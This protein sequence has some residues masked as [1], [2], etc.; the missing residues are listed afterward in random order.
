MRRAVLFLL[1]LVATLASA[2]LDEQGVLPLMPPKRWAIV[3]GAG[4]YETL[5]EL[6]YA[7]ADARDFSKL[8]VEDYKFR[9]ESV[10]KL[11]DE[12]NETP[13][14]VANIRKQLDDT[15]GDPRLN[16]GD[17][18]IFYFSGHGVGTA[19]G[20]YLCPTDATKDNITE[21][22]L[23]VKE[24][25]ERIVQ[26][27]LRN[28]LVIT[29]ACRGGEKNT[30]GQELAAL[31]EKANIGVM[32]GCEPGRRSYQNARAGHGYFTDA[33][34]EALRK[35]ELRQK[36]TGALWASDVGKY[37]SEEVAKDTSK[38]ES[39]PQVPAIEC[40]DRR[41]VMVAAFLPPSFD[42]KTLAALK[43][44]KEGLDPSKLSAT[45]A[46]Y[47][48]RLWDAA[49]LN[50]SA[51]VYRVVD[52]LTGLDPA[53]RLLLATA[54]ENSGRS[55]EA[56]VNFRK[57][58]ASDNGFY[59]DLAVL[60]DPQNGD[61]GLRLAAASRAFQQNPSASFACGLV[62]MT[63]APGDGPARTALIERFLKDAKQ[64]KE[65]TRLY[66]EGELA[67]DR[68]DLPKAEEALR[69][70]VKTFGVQLTPNRIRWQLVRVLISQLKIQESL[71]VC[72]EAIAEKGDD[73]GGWLLMRGLILRL[74]RG[75][76]D[77]AA[78]DAKAAL[79][80]ELR[81]DEML[82]AAR[83]LGSHMM[84][85]LAE[86]KSCSDANPR[87]V[88]AQII[89]YIASFFSNEKSLPF[90]LPA[91]HPAIRYAEDPKSVL[92]TYEKATASLWQDLMDD[93]A[94]GPDVMASMIDARASNLLSAVAAAGYDD[95]YWTMLAE[96]CLQ[97]R[98]APQAF[99]YFERTWSKPVAAGNV[100]ANILASYALIALSAGE[101][102]TV[103]T[104]CGIPKNR[105]YETQ[106]LPW[107][108]AIS[109][110]L[111]GDEKAAYRKIPLLG[112]PSEGYKDLANGLRLLAKIQGMEP[113][114][115]S[116]ILD[117]APKPELVVGNVILALGWLELGQIDKAAPLL[118]QAGS[119]DNWAH[120]AVD[121]Y[122]LSRLSAALH[123]AGN[124]E[125]ADQILF[126]LQFMFPWM[127]CVDEIHYGPKASLAAYAGEYKFTATQ[128]ADDRTITAT[129]A[130]YTIT[131]QGKVSGKVAAY[132]LAGTVDAKGNLRGTAIGEGKTWKVYA[133]LAPK[134]YYEKFDQL[135]A[136]NQTLILQSE[137]GPRLAY[138]LKI[139]D[140]AR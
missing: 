113:K 55:N 4:K 119:P 67:L 54:L 15:L 63:G 14:T 139:A 52:S 114:A 33:L 118:E 29:D 110:L 17:L 19:K 86:L 50:D 68:F 107:L 47:A 116:K 78:Q 30:F 93:G 101:W 35:P 106:D 8:L 128:V 71:D 43:A 104:L 10:T 59:R 21:V 135:K 76:R 91:N 58:A 7:P 51:E 32:L 102:Q 38:R 117:A 22:G 103:D 84:D 79:K 94:L 69:K 126:L 137:D 34:L 46:V 31:S 9:P 27:G 24:V 28:V 64:L 134:T 53:D 48:E 12:P 36:D 56:G 42:E 140:S 121:A 18:F 62:P 81:P 66:L 74:H 39:I 100:R 75:D 83:V 65:Q 87:S 108:Q 37:L 85:C 45:L 105:T 41:D 2:Q 133:K 111:R 89:G 99:A 61:N 129:A 73:E 131:A 125:G 120:Q 130:S 23:P 115:A 3:I 20:D 40:D 112:S 96:R 136:G 6:R 16:K 132:D 11:I 124:V 26:A 80:L 95:E 127:P 138:L 49:R 88:E 97:A 98:R 1:L 82:T 123:K 25:I 72:T 122:A 60:L 90:Q 13:P 92:I 109:L 70:A 77:G 57:V 44:V 5:G